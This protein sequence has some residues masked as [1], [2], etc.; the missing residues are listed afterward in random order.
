MNTPSPS[1]WGEL[2]DIAVSIVQQANKEW[3]VV[4]RW[5][6]GGGTALMLH[7]NHRESHDI[8]M[9]LSD[10]Q[11]LPYLNP[12]TQDMNLQ[13]EPSS[14]STDGSRALKVTFDGV[15]EIDVI[16][17]GWMLE[18]PSVREMVRG[19]SIELER[20][21]EIIAKKV[22]FRGS[23]IEPRDMFDIACVA[24][25]YGD[26]YIKEALSDIRPEAKVALEKAKGFTP[27]LASAVV[28]RLAVMPDFKD[29]Q[30]NAQP[31]A[32]KALSAAI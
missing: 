13:I 24:K 15:G 30:A 31:L 22:F 21:A 1:R 11:L 8:D 29:V 32:V 9:F 19:H 14:Y 26:E 17:C 23:R 20:P 10:P 2:L 28:G 27:T 25:H 5:T 18:N 3:S 7:I 4:D 16:C 6:L 12:E